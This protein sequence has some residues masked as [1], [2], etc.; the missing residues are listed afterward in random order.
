MTTVMDGDSVTLGRQTMSPLTKGDDQEAS[1]M[2]TSR[3]EAVGE[4]LSSLLGPEFVSTRSGPG[5]KS[6]PYIAGYNVF[7]IANR[8]FGYDG[9][10][11][12]VVE[13]RTIFCE[14]EQSSG[15][16]SV[17]VEVTGSVTLVRDGVSRE[18]LGHGSGTN[19]DKLQAFQKA[20]KE[21]GTDSYKRAFRQFGDVFGNCIYDPVYRDRIKHVKDYEVLEFD[22]E[23]LF[24][25]AVNKPQKRVLVDISGGDVD[26]HR[27]DEDVEFAE[28]C[29]LRS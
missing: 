8:I 2:E 17:G 9:F 13:V 18:D 22:T 4:Q 3:R 1:I 20:A 29:C 28:I 24:R 10:N 19:A 5:N 14:K 16:W 25:L 11:T 27:N 15:Q 21:A 26:A 23:K 12:K 6:V 7:R